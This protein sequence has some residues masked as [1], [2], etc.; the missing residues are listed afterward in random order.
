[1]KSTETFFAL[2]VSLALASPLAAQT[3]PETPAAPEAPAAQAPAEAPAQ[4]TS[5]AAPAAP[6]GMS[7]GEETAQTGTTYVKETFGD[8]Q[9]NCIRSE[10]GVDPCQAYQLLKDSEGNSV[11]EINLFNLPPGG[12]AVA[13]A[14]IVTPLETLLTAQVTVRIDSAQPK[15]YPFTLCAPIGCVARVGFTAAEVDSFRKGNKGTVTIVPAMLP[16]EQVDITLSLKGFTAAWDAMI[17]A[18]EAA[19]KAAQEAAKAQA[20]AAPKN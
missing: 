18:N 9:L 17:K 10:T 2:A 7:M 11:A 8:W 3:A 19:D 15:R 20:P 6:G 16:D 4:G 12:Q 13:G 14:S 1:M 5:P